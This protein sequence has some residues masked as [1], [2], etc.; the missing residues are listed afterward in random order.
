MNVECA[1]AKIIKENFPE[2]RK[3]AGIGLFVWNTKSDYLYWDDGMF[4]LFEVSKKDFK[5]NYSSFNAALSIGDSIRITESLKTAIDNRDD[6]VSTFAINLSDGSQKY[7]KAYSSFVND[8][9]VGVNIKITEEEYMRSLQLTEVNDFSI[10]KNKKARLSMYSLKKAFSKP[11]D[12][13]D[14]NPS[15]EWVSCNS[16]GLTNFS[17]RVLSID[18][19]KH[20]QMEWL[21]IN[22]TSETHYNNFDKLIT[23]LGKAPIIVWVNGEESLLDFGDSINITAGAMHKIKYWGS[24]YSSV[25]FFNYFSK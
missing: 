19:N 2:I 15:N 7:I 12:F 17:Y 18:K 4:Y 20:L 8:L 10:I 16:F 13:E 3:Q 21:N 24:C 6:F 25:T 1:N 22:D 23:N 14:L 11:S 9:L 5:N